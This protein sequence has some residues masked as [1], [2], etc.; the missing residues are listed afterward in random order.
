V[1]AAL[2][3]RAA[4]VERFAKLEAESAEERRSSADREG[5]LR[6]AAAEAAAAL[7]ALRARSE[8][9]TAAALEDARF[10]APLYLYCTDF[11]HFT[12]THTA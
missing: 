1:D 9:Q 6:A 10:C 8:A 3:S 12:H 11:I 4:A 2:E 7:A 5:A